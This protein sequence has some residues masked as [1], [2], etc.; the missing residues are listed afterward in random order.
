MTTS[1]T[2]VGTGA[3]D[4]L[5]ESLAS[6]GARL[7][8]EG[9]QTRAADFGSVPR[10]HRA[11]VESVGLLEG[12]GRAVVLVEGE[13]AAQMLDGLLTNHL[14]E[15]ARAGRAL[16]SFLLTARGRPVADA[17][18]IPLE[19]GSYWLDLPY[20]AVP[21]IE[22]HFSK[23]LPPRFAV[24]SR[25]PDVGRLSLVGPAS[26]E[27][28]TAASEAGGPGTLEPLEVAAAEVAGSRAVV[29]RRESVEG[30]GYDLYLRSPGLRLA[31]DALRTTV[32]A[33]GGGAVGHD[34]WEILRVE[35]GIP[36]YGSEITTDNLPQETGQTERAISFD[37]GCYT[38]QEVVVRIQ[39]RGH[40]NRHLRGVSPEEGEGA[41]ATALSAATL[42]RDGRQVGEVSSA[43]RSPRFGAI[44]L[45]YVRREVEPGETVALR[46]DRADGG[47]ETNGP[48]E[49]PVRVSELPFTEE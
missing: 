18:V 30:P 43:V 8:G 9:P 3:R 23:Y 39:H 10:E 25:E 35:R 29:V 45:A 6:S 42:H 11:L 37:K 47:G 12:A 34:A 14:A 31:W 46:P 2:D 22:E 19:E 5:L 44:G 36:A 16:Y 21:G 48:P 4:H 49:L 28:L 38:G 1:S 15:A 41:D 27:A 13:R 24:Y 32:D 33:M 26:E 40:V 20:A 7:E 17:R